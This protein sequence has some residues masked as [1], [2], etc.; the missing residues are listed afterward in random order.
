MTETET[1]LTS[2]QRHQAKVALVTGGGTGIGAA[3]AGRLVAE[4]AKVILTGRRPEPLEA[5]AERLSARAI[6]ADMSA[7][8]EV[9]AVIEQIVAEF[10]QLDLVV[11]NAGGHGFSSVAETDDESWRSSMAANLDT[12]FVTLREALPQL[13]AQQGSAVIVSSLAGLFAGPNVAGYTVGKHALIGLTKSLAR[14]YGKR[15]VR[16]NALCPGWVRTPM[17][18]AEMDEYAAA[19]GIA[20]REEAYRKVTA[21]V[22]LAR[23][24]DPAE[25]AAIASFLGSSEA[26][27]I[28][29][30]TIVADGGA[31][32]VDLPTIAFDGVL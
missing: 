3:I 16:V 5:A 6:A 32:V 11:A 28:T 26:S 23:P 24:A 19:A 12:A 27:Y 22:P 17:A 15:G 13:I 9:K 4:G 8:G 25:I 7:P 10:G 21:N 31:H 30:A 2:S 29:G 1:Q 18:D 20:S 14:D